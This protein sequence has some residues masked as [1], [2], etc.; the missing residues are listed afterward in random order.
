MKV[1]LVF[2]FLQIRSKSV[3]EDSLAK[4]MTKSVCLTLFSLNHFLFGTPVKEE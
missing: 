1:H 3:E 2:I 4:V